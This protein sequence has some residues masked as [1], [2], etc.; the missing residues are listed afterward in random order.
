MA[1]TDPELIPDKT[2][3]KFSI[4]IPNKQFL[5]INNNILE[6]TYKYCTELINVKTFEDAKYLLKEKS[7]FKNMEDIFVESIIY[8]LKKLDKI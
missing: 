3:T 4:K 2:S 8:N 6:L 7:E 1:K 5:Y